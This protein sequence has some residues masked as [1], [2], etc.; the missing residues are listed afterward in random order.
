MLPSFLARLPGRYRVRGTSLL[1]ALHHGQVVRIAK[2]QPQRGSIIVF[3]SPDG[4]DVKRVVA[5]PHETVE[6]SG[7]RVLADGQ[8]VARAWPKDRRHWKLGNDFFVL[9]DNAE[10]SR[11]SRDYGPVPAEGIIGVVRD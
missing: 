9:G 6:I 10:N 7:D 3:M 11:D 5:L 8:E 4:L 2:A 1:P